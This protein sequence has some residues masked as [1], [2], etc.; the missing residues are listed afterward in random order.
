MLKHGSEANSMYDFIQRK[1]ANRSW[2]SRN[3][4]TSDEL[5]LRHGVGNDVYLFETNHSH[6]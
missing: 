6:K 1:I 3:F 2:Q 4:P 5:I